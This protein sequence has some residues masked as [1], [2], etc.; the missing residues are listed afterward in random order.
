M[1]K[2]NTTKQHSR[3][4]LVPPPKAQAAQVKSYYSSHMPQGVRCD[5]IIAL[6]VQD[7][8]LEDAG[9]LPGDV[10]IAYYTNEVKSGD[11]VTWRF[12]DDDASTH[13]LRRFYTAPDKRIRM[14]R[15]ENGERLA[16]IYEA[17]KIV[18]TGRLIQVERK[19]HVIPVWVT[20]RPPYE[21]A[22]GAR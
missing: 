7:F 2:K 9:L 16:R 20:L 18:V 8:S 22:G 15:T 17:S 21:Y 13:Y 14:E 4:S 19:G 3:L 11:I 10:A 5:K 12:A 6:M 1:Q